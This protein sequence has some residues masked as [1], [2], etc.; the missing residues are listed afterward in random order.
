MSIERLRNGGVDVSL[1]PSALLIFGERVLKCPETTETVGLFLVYGWRTGN[2][3]NYLV[4]GWAG[5]RTRRVWD[6][7]RRGLV[8]GRGFDW[9]AGHRPRDRY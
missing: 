9:R 4:I 3:Y 2:K 8:E 1:E 5:R 6:S 7:I